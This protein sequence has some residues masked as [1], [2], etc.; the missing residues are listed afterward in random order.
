MSEG[1][2]TGTLRRRLAGRVVGCR[3]L[4]FHTLGSTMDEGQRLADEGSP[5]G[6]VV[7][8]EEQTGGRGRFNRKWVTSPGDDISFSTI[9]R[10]DP[11]QLTYVN[12]AA[13]L[14]VSDA[15]VQLT[16]LEPAIKWPND[17]RINGRKVSGILTEG[18]FESNELRHVVVGIGLNVNS[19]PSSLPEI[20]SIATSLRNETGRPLDRTTTALTLLERLDDLYGEV[21]E[22]QSLTE[23]WSAQ[24][25]TLGQ[26]VQVRWAD[27]VSEGVA[28]G[29][30]E[31]GNLLLAQPDGSTLTLRAGEVTLQS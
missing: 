7:I 2:D 24:I 15:I 10:P 6:T 16:G 12:M 30:D 17:V 26:S 14:A 31:Q 18:V 29:V 22:G 4:H 21:R 25:S 8:T 27:Q 9:L 19:D 23:R 3:I 5:E 20:A 13:A 11:A 28:S 1:F